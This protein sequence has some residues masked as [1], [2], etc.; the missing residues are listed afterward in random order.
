[1]Y[2]DLICVIDISGSMRGEKIY[3]VKESLKILLTLMDEKDRICLILF[4][5]SAQNYYDLNYLTKENKDI[6]INKIDKIYSGG[7]TNILSGLQIAI[8]VL[9]KELN[10]TKKEQSVP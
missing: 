8:D 9:K 3:Q 6:L 10:N 5:E 1:M 7:G 4:N 2:A